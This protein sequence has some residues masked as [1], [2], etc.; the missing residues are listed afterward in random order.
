MPLFIAFCPES[1]LLSLHEI[2]G[3]QGNR[4][5]HKKLLDP[6]EKRKTVSVVFLYLNFQILV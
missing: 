6:S 3:T 5:V 4:D 1:A 2:Q